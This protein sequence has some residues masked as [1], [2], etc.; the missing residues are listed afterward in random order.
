MSGL[1]VHMFNW[2]AGEEPH[3]CLGKAEGQVALVM[4]SYG[5]VEI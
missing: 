3:K 1:A 5:E 2:S 4:K